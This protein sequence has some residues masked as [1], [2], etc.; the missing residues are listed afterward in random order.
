MIAKP[1][2]ADVEPVPGA[3]QV[4]EVLLDPLAP[5]EDL[6]LDGSHRREPFEVRRGEGGEGIDLTVTPLSDLR[7]ST[8]LYNLTGTCTITGNMIAG[9]PLK[10]N[11]N[12]IPS[13]TEMPTW[14]PSMPSPTCTNDPKGTSLVTRP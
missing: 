13:S 5:P 2:R 8:I 12:Y 4:L 7:P 1:A 14:D 3:A 10:V 11:P 6:A 9:T